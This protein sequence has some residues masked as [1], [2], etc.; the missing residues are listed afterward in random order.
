ME[1][2]LRQNNPQKTALVS[3]NGTIHYEITTTKTGTS[4]ET[5]D[6]FLCKI[7]HPKD[8]SVVGEIEWGDCFTP[9]FVR[10]PLFSGIGAQMGKMGF[11]MTARTFLYKRNPFSNSRYFVDND[12]IE[13]KWKARKG[14]GCILT[15]VHDNKEIAKYTMGS[16]V[17]GSF[18]GEKK[19]FLQIQP[20]S[21]DLDLLIL[22]FAIM[23]K[24]RR[25]R[26]DDLATVPHEDEVQGDG[27]ADG[28]GEA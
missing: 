3:P 12:L 13:Y 11:G 18:A 24:K 27:A 17:E 2:I 19:T 9:T 25:E 20:C 21:L 7:K 16:R 28:G 23:E 14:V 10:C 5:H 6:V 22:S 26:T 8:G 1:L 15:R 4:R